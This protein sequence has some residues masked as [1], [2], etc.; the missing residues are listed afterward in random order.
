M[1]RRHLA[2]AL[3]FEGF[4][5]E[6]DGLF[7]LDPAGIAH[8]VAA[9]SRALDLLR[10]LADRPG[11]VVPKDV[12]FEAVWRGRSVEEGNLTVQV[13]ALRRIL[14]RDRAHGSCIQTVPGHGYR[15]V[16]SVEAANLSTPFCTPSMKSPPRLS[17]AVLPFVN[18]SGDPE[19]AYFADGISDNLTTDLSRI[20]GMLVIAHSTALRYRN[21]QIFSEHLGRELNVR[22][23]LK[24]SV[25]R[26]GN[27]IYVNVQLIDARTDE[28][29]WADR[30][31][32]EGDDPFVLQNEI[33]GQIADALDAELIA[34][35][36]GRSTG[37]PDA[38]DY[39]L[40]GRAAARSLPS[41]SSHGT[42]IEMYERAL[43]LDCRSSEA[44][45]RLGLELLRRALD[46]MSSSHADD[47]AR[48]EVLID[49]A[50]AM[51]PRSSL[52]HFARG[53]LLRAQSRH[54]AAAF[55]YETVIAYDRNCAGAYANLGWCRLV[56]GSIDEVIPLEETA[57]RLSPRDP[58]I[59]IFYTRIG[60][61]H[62]LE[63]RIDKALAW[64]EKARLANPA[65]SMPRVFL[66]AAYALKGESEKAAIELAVA[67]SSRGD[68]F[69]SI[70]RL[71]AG[72]YREM[73]KDRALL[74]DSTWLAGLRKAG[75]PEHG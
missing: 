20:A 33:T 68:R 46:Y 24:G 69:S 49:E 73:S 36:I 12:I 48:A 26:T 34:E 5:L 30:I 45:V 51:S 22:Y 59:C 28:Y 44:R 1:D 40:R 7:R 38:F 16:S 53:H 18:L 43:A 54:G 67:R 15:F 19:Q 31:E 35:E 61:V 8:P 75:M 52:G 14:D 37:H 58:Y 21:T 50:L 25:R 11:E 17:I 10:L 64:L 62:L 32:N 3:L 29:L 60:V 74:F 55:E 39:I 57:I 65:H 71:K 42:A 66:A 47:I 63:S 4:R 6:S 9:G 23:I 27:K 13:A 2:G 41:A 72:Q 56:A 70:A